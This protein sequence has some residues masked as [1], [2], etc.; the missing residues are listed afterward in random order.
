MAWK[1]RILGRTQQ[2]QQQPV[3]PVVVEQPQQQ[4]VQTQTAY[5]GPSLEDL[6]EG[7]A[8]YA[9]HHFRIDN[10]TTAIEQDLGSEMYR[11]DK[12]GNQ[13]RLPGKSLV[14]ND[15]A[16]EFIGQLTVNGGQAT[17]LN[18]QEFYGNGRQNKALAVSETNFLPVL[19]AMAIAAALVEA[20]S[21]VTVQSRP[22]VTSKVAVNI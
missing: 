21:F 2:P 11:K 7:L 6:A 22:K 9:R 8:I 20:G 4:P 19:Q 3:Q 14:I 10:L 5:D 17:R 16:G 1:T 13:V 15:S 12:S 18:R